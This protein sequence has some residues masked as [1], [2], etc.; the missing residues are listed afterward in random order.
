MADYQ[1]NIDAEYEAIDKII[2]AFPTK[3]L[4]QISELELAGVAAFLH[5]FYNG[6]E[7]VLKQVFFSKK[8]EIPTGESWHRDLILTAVKEN[9]ISEL[10]SNKL[11]R[12][13]AFR[14]FFSHAYALELYPERM[15]PLVTDASK[16][17][18]DFK[19]EIKKVKF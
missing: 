7:N 18:E 14:H 11:K 16:I 3:D 13:L 6:I 8:L 12:F 19:K 15:K 1:E 2:S 17:F 5:N 9:I 4:S 10:L